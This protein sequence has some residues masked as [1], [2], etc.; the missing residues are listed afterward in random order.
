MSKEIKKGRKIAEN[1]I[2]KADH[3]KKEQVTKLRSNN[4]KIP[5]F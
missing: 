3:T 4:V 1:Y 2:A 5:S